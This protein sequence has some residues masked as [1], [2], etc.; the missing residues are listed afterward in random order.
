MPGHTSALPRANARVRSAFVSIDALTRPGALVRPGDPDRSS[1]FWRLVDGHSGDAASASRP[2]RTDGAARAADWR[3][4]GIVRRWI[5]SLPGAHL[6]TTSQTLRG[7]FMWPDRRSGVRLKTNRPTYSPGR[8]IVLRLHARAPCRLT[9]INVDTRGVATVVFP[10]AYANGNFMDTEAA[11]QLPAPDA[12]FVFKARRRGSEKLIALCTSGRGRVLGIRQNFDV[13]R[14]TVLGDWEVF[15]RT[16]KQPSQ[17]TR[18]PARRRLWRVVKRCRTYRRRSKRRRRCRYRRVRR[19]ESGRPAQ[20]VTAL[21]HAEIE[22]V[23][24]KILQIK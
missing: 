10:N 9:L 3:W 21:A 22:S 16:G 7:G 24:V 1:L 4:V 15:L 14:F 20:P 23:S 18:P 6:Q 8:R 11:F 2:D 13:Q 19:R 5:A 12:P 17:V